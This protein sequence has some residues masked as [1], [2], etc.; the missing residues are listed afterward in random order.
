MKTPVVV[1]LSSLWKNRFSSFTQWSV[2]LRNSRIGVFSNVFA[3]FLRF[4]FRKF[5][6]FVNSRISPVLP[7]Y[8]P[9][10]T[11]NNFQTRPCREIS[12]KFNALYC[13]YSLLNLLVWR[14]PQIL[15]RFL[16]GSGFLHAAGVVGLVTS[17]F[18]QY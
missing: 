7:F 13:P 17:K 18:F 5:H 10:D 6:R 4:V 3:Y 2:T 11:Y 16:K 8:W 12:V 14:P 1:I 15:H 9:L